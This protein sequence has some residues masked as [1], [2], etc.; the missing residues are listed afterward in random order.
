MNTGWKVLLTHSNLLQND[1]KQQRKMRPYPP[2]A[3]IQAA[4]ILRDA[5][6]EVALCDPTFHASLDNFYDV[7]SSFKPDILIIYE[8]YFNFIAKMCLGHM[9]RS[10]QAMCRA[11]REAG[12]ITIVASPDTTDHPQEYL[13][14]GADYALIGEA[15]RTVI[16]ICRCLLE[17]SDPIEANVAGVA[18]YSPDG[19]LKITAPRSLEK[20][21][22]SLPMPAWDM[23]QTE[24]YRLAWQKH[25]RYF[26]LNMVSSR[27]CPFDCNWCAKP[28]WGNHFVQRPAGQVAQELSWVSENLKPDHIWFADDNFGYSESWIAEFNS[29]LQEEGTRIPYTIQTRADLLTPEVISG[30]RESGCSE[31]WLGAE[32]GSQRILNAMNKKIR[33]ED[34]REAVVNLKTAGIRTGLFFQFGYPG[35]TLEDIFASVEFIRE[36]FPDEIGVSVTYPLPGTPLYDAVKDNIGGRTQWQDSD[37]LAMLFQ[38]AYTTP[39]YRKLHKVLHAELDLRHRTAAGKYRGN[40]EEKGLWKKVMEGWL[41]LGEMEAA[42]RR[43]PCGHHGGN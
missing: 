41:D 12:A 36:T 19:E 26:S 9:R 15:D 22:A 16:E 39:F 14:N 38:G 23:I 24:P 42:Y 11:A 31:A 3:T 37:D 33:L 32:S 34:L 1:S 8:D 10:A 29:A 40:G 18:C 5:G 43:N 2:L 35:E 27:G 17:G 4:A 7:M 28:I 21:L 20:N 6:F 30:L 25:H 13:Q